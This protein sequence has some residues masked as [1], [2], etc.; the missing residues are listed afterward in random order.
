MVVESLAILAVI[1][2]MAAM[3]ARSGRRIFSAFT[4]PLC[5]IPLFHIV[6]RV[7]R[8]SN[9]AVLDIAGFVVGVLLCLLFSKAFE[10]KRSRVGYLVFCCAFMAAL[11]VAYLINAG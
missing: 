7:F 8:L 2:V 1:L 4:L 5:S 10:Q 6:G 3:F 9:I 11:L